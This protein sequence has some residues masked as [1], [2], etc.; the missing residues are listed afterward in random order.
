MLVLLLAVVVQALGII[1]VPILTLR[2]TATPVVSSFVL[3]SPSARGVLTRQQPRQGRKQS[4]RRR[5][6]TLHSVISGDDDDD[7]DNITWEPQDLTQDKEGYP[8]IPPND[9]IKQYQA[10]P[11]CLWPVEFFVVAYRRN[12]I[13]AGQVELLVR[14]SS[15]GTSKYGLGTGVPVTRWGYLRSDGES[16]DHQLLPQGYEIMR[17]EQHTNH[18]NNNN[19]LSSSSSFVEL[20]DAKN[21]SEFRAGT[22]SNSG[23][24]EQS[25]S[26]SKLDLKTTAFQDDD[27]LM[28]PELEEYATRIRNSLKDH[29]SSSSSSERSFVSSLSSLSS[30]QPIKNDIGETADEWESI[31]TK[32]ITDYILTRPNS[33]TAIQGSLR[34]SGLFAFVDKYS[35]SNSQYDDDDDNDPTRRYIPLN[36]APD[37]NWIATQST[38]IYTMFPQMPNPLPHPE[39]PASELRHEL[40]TRPERMATSGRNP[41]VDKYGRKYTHISTSNVSNTIHGIYMCLDVTDLILN[42]EDNNNSNPFDHDNIPPALDLFGTQRVDRE[43]KSLQDLKILKSDGTLDTT[44]PKPTFISGFIVR[45][46]VK[47]GIIPTR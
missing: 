2:I 44:D 5:T 31:R 22:C 9:Y 25:W 21:F 28:D 40:Q 43:W 19:R 41:H 47:E 37:P 45:Q 35:N 33:A 38:R 1:C 32:L 30:Q 24:D 42:D 18:K 29:L 16:H 39:T 10:S 34:M 27:F 6:R 7:D 3:P 20:F 26:Y 12:P 14:P 8:P 15:N 17:H 46:L 36:N 4:R 11:T 23:N 13:K